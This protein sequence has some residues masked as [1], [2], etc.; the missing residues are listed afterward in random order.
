MLSATFFPDPDQDALLRTTLERVNRACDAV[1]KAAF[2]AGVRPGP[3]FKDAIK[4]HSAAVVERFGLASPYPS[5]VVARVAKAMETTPSKPPR[6]RDRQAIEYTA[7]QLKWSSPERVAFP[8]WKGRRNLR[9]HLDPKAGP[10]P[11]RA[12]LEGHASALV[13]RNGRLFLDA[14]DVVDADED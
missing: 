14:T 13:E 12:P 9:I 6:F 11:L 4:E 1:G 5:L 2:N 8:T 10:V 3:K 7:G